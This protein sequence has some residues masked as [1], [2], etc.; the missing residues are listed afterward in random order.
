MTT[1]VGKGFATLG[2]THNLV[3]QRTPS[4][5]GVVSSGWIPAENVQFLL[6]GVVALTSPSSAEGRL[7]VGVSTGVGFGYLLVEEIGV[8][9]GKRAAG[10][11]QVSDT[12]PCM[13]VPGVATAPHAVELHRGR[14]VLL[15]RLW[16]SAQHDDHRQPLQKRCVPRKRGDQ[17]GRQILRNHYAGQ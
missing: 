17:R 11:V 8:T 2:I 12:G 5:F 9:S 1:A 16:L 7:A 3:N 13:P 10:V 14:V 15:L 6:N 4:A